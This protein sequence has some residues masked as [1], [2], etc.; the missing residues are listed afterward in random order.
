MEVHIL[1]SG[2]D[3]NCAVVRHD[4]TAIIIDAGLTRKETLKLMAS[5]GIDDLDYSGIFIT[6]EHSDH[7]KGAGVVARAFDCPIYCN[8]PTFDACCDKLGK[9]SHISTNMLKP[10]TI[11]TITITPLPTSHDAKYPCCYKFEAG[12]KMGIIAT[13]T[14]YFKT[15]VRQALRD[16]DIAVM[17]SNYDKRMLAEGPYSD[18]L[19]KRIDSDLGHVSNL[20][21]AR[22]IKEIFS[23][24]K[25]IFL[26]HLSKTNNM[27]DVAKDTASEITGVRKQWFDCLD[28]YSVPND[29]R[30]LRC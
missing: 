16:A 17:E 15:E 4:D 9:V 30:V 3:G 23:P 1:A 28:T 20:M 19:K 24:S 25:K 22:T 2:S 12:G 18:W 21:C 8:D 7:I 13:D 14:G 11:G 29:T 5:N 26:A 10:V 27:P 6:H